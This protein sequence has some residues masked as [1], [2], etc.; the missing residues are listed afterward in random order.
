MF[1]QDMAKMAFGLKLGRPDNRRYRY[2]GDR[3]DMLESKPLMGPDA[4]GVYWEPVRAYFENDETLMVFQP[5]HPDDL[6]DR[7]ARKI[8]TL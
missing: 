7:V 4:H 3:R 1:D 8:D 2:K 6:G 5:I